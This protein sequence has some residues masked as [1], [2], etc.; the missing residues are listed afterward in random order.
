[1]L[2]RIFTSLLIG[3]STLVA[4]P[5]LAQVKQAVTQNPALLNT[6][7]AKAAMAEKG[8]SLTDVKQKIAETSSTSN[9]ATSEATI[10][11]GT[12]S[13]RIIVQDNGIGFE[14]DMAEQIFETFTRLNSKDKYEGTG[15]SLSVEMNLQP[16][17]IA[18]DC[19]QFVHS[20]VTSTSSASTWFKKYS[21]RLALL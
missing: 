21:M 4:E 17:L 9:D 2:F 18:F 14:P 19:I 20:N 7:Q 13:S 15:D 10:E 16:A 6:P 5:S 1:M 3:F 12:I 11:S 8:V